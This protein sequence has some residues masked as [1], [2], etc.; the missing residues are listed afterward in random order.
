LFDKLHDIFQ[1]VSQMQLQLKDQV[2]VRNFHRFFHKILVCFLL[3]FVH[4]RFVNGKAKFGEKLEHL[5]FPLENL[6]VETIDEVGDQWA[7]P[8]P[9]PFSPNCTKP[10]LWSKIDG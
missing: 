7:C 2:F 3:C 8:H 10:K 5:F 9:N 1:E 4:K 6:F